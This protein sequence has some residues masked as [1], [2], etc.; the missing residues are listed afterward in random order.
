MPE[1]YKICEEKNINIY[2]GK[3]KKIKKDLLEEIINKI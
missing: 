2:S 3:K 1:L